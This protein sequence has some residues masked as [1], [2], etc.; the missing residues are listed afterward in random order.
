MR[1][2][3]SRGPRVRTRTSRPMRG[4][5][6]RGMAVGSLSV[7]TPSSRPGGG[8]LRCRRGRCPCGHD[9][10]P[11]LRRRAVDGRAPSLAP[12][13][14]RRVCVRLVTPRRSVCGEAGD[15]PALHTVEELEPPERRF[16]D[17]APRPR[18]VYARGESCPPRYGLGYLHRCSFACPV[19]LPGVEPGSDRRPVGACC[20][21]MTVRGPCPTSRRGVPPANDSAIPLA[22]LHR[23]RVSQCICREARDKTTRSRRRTRRTH[24]PDSR[25]GLAPPARF[26]CER[27]W[28]TCSGRCTAP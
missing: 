23:T 3:G 28:L 18:P 17:D 2:C 5:R 15:S 6:R 19:D 16:G 21:R 22:E 20:R 7:A 25:R 13:P 8:C 1:G 24:E 14:T 27:T 26:R 9:N 12:V 10:G 4:S 11:P